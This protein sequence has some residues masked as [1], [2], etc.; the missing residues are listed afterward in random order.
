M[1]QLIMLPF[2]LEFRCGTLGGVAHYYAQAQCCTHGYHMA[3]TWLSHGYYHPQIDAEP[4]YSDTT[5]KHN[6]VSK[7]KYRQKMQICQHFSVESIQ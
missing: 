3:V 7:Q 4:E 2:G 5:S 1:P 6:M